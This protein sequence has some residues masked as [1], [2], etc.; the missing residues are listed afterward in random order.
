MADMFLKY[1]R[2]RVNDRIVDTLIGISAG[3]VADGIVTQSEAE[4]LHTW[5]VQNRDLTDNPVV[6]NLL[7][8]VA[9]MLEDGVL[10][11]DESAELLDILQKFSGSPSELGELAHTSSL[12]LD[13]PVP[14]IVFPGRSFLFTGTCVYG[15]R[16]QCEEATAALGGTIAKS[17]TK[18]VNYLVL[19]TYVSDSWIHQSFG[20]KIE[21]AIEYRSQGLP[22][23]IIAEETWAAAGNL[24][25]VR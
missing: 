9:M 7:D 10:D 6:S 11:P 13:V 15:S 5:L 12:P 24:A 8:R 20:R 21:K 18:G 2:N 17:M 19:G 1:N 23:A 3:I 14:A 25:P 22:L 4:F 16:R